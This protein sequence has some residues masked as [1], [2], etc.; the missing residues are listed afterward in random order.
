MIT[1][2]TVAGLTIGTIDS[3]LNGYFIY[4]TSG[5]DFPITRVAVTDNGNYNGARLNRALYGRRVMSIEGE[6]IADSPETY[7]TMRR[8]MQEAFD[9]MRGLQRATIVTRGG[10]SVR[11][12]VILNNKLEQPYEK[13]MVVR[14]EFRLELTAP[15][16]YFVGDVE[17]SSNVYI[18]AGGGGE[19]PME[20]PFEMGSGLSG[21]TVINNAGNTQAI[22]RITI[23]GE[24]TDPQILNATTGEQL[25]I[26]YTL[27]AD[28]YIELDFYTRTARLNGSINI[29]NNVSGTWWDLERGNN[30][31]RLVGASYAGEA[32]AVI[33]YQDYFLGI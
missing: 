11:A 6:I 5:F 20:I 32:R 13:G 24:I 8:A 16:P 19:I 1:S 33:T 2:L 27:G 21:D 23:Y 18:F 15:F 7:E 31:I 30:T 10:N 4:R 3:N 28:D 12:D 9:V 25:S 22:P 26:D 29:F 14:G 17:N